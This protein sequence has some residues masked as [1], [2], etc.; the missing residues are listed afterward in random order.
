M[1]Q[2][3]KTSA[4]PMRNDSDISEYF[5]WLVDKAGGWDQRSLLSILHSI[6]FEW[7]VCNDSNREDDGAYQR[8]IFHEETGQ[9]IPGDYSRGSGCSVLEMLVGLADSMHELMYG[10]QEG[11]CPQLWFQTFIYNMRLGYLNDERFEMLPEESEREARRIIRRFLKR[12][13]S[14]DGRGGIFPMPGSS[15]DVRKMEL[16]YQMN[17]YCDRILLEMYSNFEPAE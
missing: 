17:A 16:W 12:E 11:S 13:Y 15:T 1:T 10:P 4:N 9:D 8:W 2:T 7:D 6:P 5:E 3:K 14:Y